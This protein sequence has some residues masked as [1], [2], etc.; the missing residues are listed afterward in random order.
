[1]FTGV[2]GIWFLTD[3]E[4]DLAARIHGRLPLHAVVGAGVHGPETYD[5]E[6]FRRRHGIDGRF[7]YYS[8]RREGAKN[9]G[10]LVDAFGAAVERHGLP[11]KLVTSGVG[12]VRPPKELADRVVDLGRLSRD[13]V[14]NTFA[15][16]DAYLQPSAL[17]SFSVAVMDAWLAGTPVIA[18]AASEVVRW[19]VERS[20]AGLLF[21]DDIELG[22]CLKYVADEPKN[23]LAA[24]GRAYVLEN[25]RWPDVLDRMES[26]LDEWFPA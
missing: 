9:W 7:V 18:N 26:T 23:D 16:A 25:Y 3:P 24:G 22:W 5:T 13:E 1:V 6:G 20:G 10:W 15:A 12:D 2:R 14:P 19:H 8:G 17:E 11:F 4:R 21:E